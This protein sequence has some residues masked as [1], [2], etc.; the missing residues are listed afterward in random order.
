MRRKM[1]RINLTGKTVALLL[2]ISVAGCSGAGVKHHDPMMD[3][4]SVQAVAVMPFV[5]LTRD[6]AAAERVRDTFSTMLL[7]TGALYVL[8]PGEVARG[9]ARSGM[10]DMTRPSPDEVKK[11]TGV[12]KTDAVITGVV[13]EYGELRSGQ[14]AANVIS[15]SLQMLDSQ[16]GTVVWAADT[17][18]GGISMTDRLFGGGG[19]PMDV[20]TREAVDDL[21]D[22]LFE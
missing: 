16:T 20:V 21:L 7:A 12:T 15:L 9:I 6:E 1:K 14:T 19:E 4:G 5:N 18:R 2:L 8:P 13:R 10:A 17:T 3:F 22:K 11:F